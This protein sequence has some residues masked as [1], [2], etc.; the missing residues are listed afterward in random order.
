MRFAI[1]LAVVFCVGAAAHGQ[2][3]LGRVAQLEA[4]TEANR[5]KIAEHDDRIA[6]LEATVAELKAKAAPTVTASAPAPEPVAHYFQLPD[7]RLVPYGQQFIDVNPPVIAS[8]SAPSYYGAAYGGAAGGCANGQCGAS[9]G[10]TGFFGR[11]R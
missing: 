11:R 6:K 5:K 2:D 3:L 9:A 4:Q 7:G 1:S 10:R 8:Y